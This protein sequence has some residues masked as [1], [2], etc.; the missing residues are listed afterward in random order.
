ME[1]KEKRNEYMR[2]YRNGDR[3]RSKVTEE[4]RLEKNGHTTVNT[5]VSTER[6]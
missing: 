1:N 3:R 6:I 5:S 2:D 4:E